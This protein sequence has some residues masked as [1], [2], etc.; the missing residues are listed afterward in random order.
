MIEKDFIALLHFAKVISRS[1]I[2]HAC[3]AGLAFRDEVQPRIGGWLLFHQPKR[4]HKF[5]IPSSQHP[6]KPQ[7]IMFTALDPV[8]VGVSLQLE[9]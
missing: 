6:E 1:V 5:Q 3:P 8:V 9:C 2:A 7:A 4:S